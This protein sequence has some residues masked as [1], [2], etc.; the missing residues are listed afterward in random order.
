MFGD[1]NRVLSPEHVRFIAERTEGEI[2][3]ETEDPMVVLT[4]L[5]KDG[6]LIRFRVEGPDLEG[7]FLNLTGRHLRD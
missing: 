5:Q 2:R 3:I 1:K 4:R 7:V 6:G